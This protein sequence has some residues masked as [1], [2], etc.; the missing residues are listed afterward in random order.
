VEQGKDASNLFK[1]T[2]ISKALSTRALSIV[3]RKRLKAL[4]GEKV[5]L[6]FDT[7]FMD[8]GIIRQ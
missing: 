6:I 2:N 3:D 8:F 5:A 4:K 1:K 7:C